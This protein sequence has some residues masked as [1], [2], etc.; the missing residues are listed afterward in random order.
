[1]IAALDNFAEG[2][3]ISFGQVN[4]KEHTPGLSVGGLL[5]L[6]V[7]GLGAF[8]AYSQIDKVMRKADYAY[9]D[10]SVLLKNDRFISDIRFGD[11]E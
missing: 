10:K 4:K 1:M 11:F 2:V 8:M 6:M 5:R 9:T 7:S 3:G